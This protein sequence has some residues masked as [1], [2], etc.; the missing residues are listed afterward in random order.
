MKNDEE[1][2]MTNLVWM[3]LEMITHSSHSHRSKNAS[4]RWKIQNIEEI[5]KNQMVN[6]ILTYFTI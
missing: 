6:E 4:K 1:G 2:K 3:N 5:G